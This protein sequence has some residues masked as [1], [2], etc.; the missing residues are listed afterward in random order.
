VG[1]IVLRI[2]GEAV[3][4]SIQRQLAGLHAGDTLK[5]QLRNARGERELQW[6]VGSRAEV[7]FELKDVENITPQQKARRAAWLRGESQSEAHR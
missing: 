2:N 4:P 7:E 3:E 6:K 5:L 1:D